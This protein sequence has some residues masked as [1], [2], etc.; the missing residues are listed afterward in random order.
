MRSGSVFNFLCHDN[1]TTGRCVSLSNS[2][3]GHLKAGGWGVF[4]KPWEVPG[5]FVMSKRMMLC[6][7]TT[8]D[9]H[10]RRKNI[11]SVCVCVYS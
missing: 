7:N 8:F 1:E 6:S 10:D 5:K 11:L 3:G 4:F 2:D 9:Q